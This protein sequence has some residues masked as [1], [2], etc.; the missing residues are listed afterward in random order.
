MGI[1]QPFCPLSPTLPNFSQW[2]IPIVPMNML[3]FLLSYKKTQL[4]IPSPPPA[5]LS[6]NSLLQQNPQ[7]L[8]PVT[9]SLLF[10][11]PFSDKPTLPWKSLTSKPPVTSMM[12]ILGIGSRSL[13]SLASRQHSAHLLILLET[14]PLHGFQGGTLPHLTAA[15]LFYWDSL[16]AAL[17]FQSSSPRPFHLHSQSGLHKAQ[18][19]SL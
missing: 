7:K 18:T 10:F 5:A 11:L 8:L 14:R 17:C 19:S 9:F 15:H 1:A 6:L 16:P 3:T 13:L 4:L 12:P 2:I